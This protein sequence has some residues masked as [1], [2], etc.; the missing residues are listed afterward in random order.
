[1]AGSLRVTPIVVL[2]GELAAGG[3][4]YAP[5]F[6]GRGT[7]DQVRFHALAETAAADPTTLT[8]RALRTLERSLDSHGRG[9]LTRALDA[10]VQACHQ[11]LREANAALD[12]A[13]RVGVGL[14]CLALR[15]DEVTVARAGPGA[16]HL[17]DST[18]VRRVAE[19]SDAR[20]ALGITPGAVSVAMER[21]ALGPGQ[22]LLAGGSALGRA[23]G[24]DGLQAIMSSTPE[25]TARTLHLLMAEE[26]LFT[27]LIVSR[28]A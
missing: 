21:H 9:S 16:V 19:G 23:V 13:S 5:S 6:P 22:T 8:E 14:T 4:P 17:V 27:A 24:Y 3:S 1:M 26:L 12:I 25:A 20:E 7:L 2:E 15:D 11:D 10:A 28:P 18:G